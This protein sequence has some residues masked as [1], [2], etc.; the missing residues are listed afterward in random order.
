[1]TLHF[2][3]VRIKYLLNASSTLK[4]FPYT[5]P[6]ILHNYANQIKLLL[7]LKMI[8]ETEGKIK[9]GILFHTSRVS[10]HKI[11]PHVYPFRTPFPLQCDRPA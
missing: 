8:M 6:N 11:P 7:H 2:K 4:H 1:M 5:I 3:Q 9:I 10:R